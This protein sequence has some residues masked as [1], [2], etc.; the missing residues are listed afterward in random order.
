MK[1]RYSILASVLFLGACS[2]AFSLGGCLACTDGKGN[3]H[4]SQ[5]IT[6][7]AVKNPEAV[8]FVWAH[9]LGHIFERHAWRN[10]RMERFQFEADDFAENVMIMME[11]SPCPGARL[12]LELGAVERAERL[13]SRNS[14]SGGGG[15]FSGRNQ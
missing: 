2:S 8:A 6:K 4:V 13:L 15:D 10:G 11:M 12:L 5:E 9:E 14:C 7:R 3:I 1:L